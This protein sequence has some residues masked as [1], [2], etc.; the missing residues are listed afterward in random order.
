MDCLKTCFFPNYSAEPEYPT[1]YD[2]ERQLRVSRWIEENPMFPETHSTTSMSTMWENI[3]LESTVTETTHFG[4]S[5]TL[6]RVTA[7]DNLVALDQ[8]QERELYTVM[9]EE[10]PPPPNTPVLVG[11]IRCVCTIEEELTVEEQPIS[12]RE[13][14]EEEEVPSLITRLLRFFM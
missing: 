6:H 1:Y 7:V 3:S 12:Q 13:E 10:I 8:P 11:Q 2:V 4:G 14:E 5:R 9:E